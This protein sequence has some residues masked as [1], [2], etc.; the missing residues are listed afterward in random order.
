M[1]C[2]VTLLSVDNRE[3]L[4]RRYIAKQRRGSSTSKRDN[5]SVVYVVDHVTQFRL[6]GLQ[7]FGWP[8]SL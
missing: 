2:M 7:Y 4:Y 5:S 1:S 3:W 6:I 8:R